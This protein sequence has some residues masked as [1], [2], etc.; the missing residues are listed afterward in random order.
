MEFLLYIMTEDVCW[1]WACP[2]HLRWYQNNMM[3]RHDR[4]ETHLDDKP[5]NYN[6][7]FAIIHT[8][9]VTL[10]FILSKA[11]HPSLHSVSQ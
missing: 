6:K 7:Y 5:G 1:V 8:D 2:P 10:E 9:V 3:M 4:N 11:T